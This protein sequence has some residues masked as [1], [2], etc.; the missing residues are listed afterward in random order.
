MRQ[1]RA[2]AERLD[3]D[4]AEARREPDFNE[5]LRAV[6][7]FGGDSFDAVRDD[8][9]GRVVS[10]GK[11]EERLRF[12]VEK[13]AVDAP[14]APVFRDDVDFRKRGATRERAEIDFA[15]VRRNNELR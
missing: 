10:G 1:R 6:K 3:A 5:T 11:G 9:N 8:V 2:G 7:R 4:V 15:N 12:R 14:K 13:N